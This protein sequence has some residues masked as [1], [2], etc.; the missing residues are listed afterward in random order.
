MS[1]RLSANKFAHQL[2]NLFD[3]TCNACVL[4]VW[5]GIRRTHGAPPEQAAPLMPRAGC[6]LRGRRRRSR[7]RCRRGV[8]LEE[9][10]GVG[11]CS[12]EARHVLN[13]AA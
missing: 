8:N 4:A 3:S 12:I 2:H 1:R 7:P 10:D 5:E 11:V 6:S 9:S 13:P